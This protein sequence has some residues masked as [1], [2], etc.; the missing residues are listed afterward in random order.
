MSRKSVRT[1]DRARSSYSAHPAVDLPA[2]HRPH[3]HTT[4]NASS[5][6][7]RQYDAP[8][9]SEK[10]TLGQR[11]SAA[12]R[13]GRDAP[14][15]STTTRDQQLPRPVTVWLDVAEDAGRR[16]PGSALAGVG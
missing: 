11:A 10:T 7:T 1:P 9:V 5:R 2:P 3:N 12:D 16:V 4:D 13:L 6:T 15:S 14:L 8:T